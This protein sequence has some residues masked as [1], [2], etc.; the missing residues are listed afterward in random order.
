MSLKRVGFFGGT[1]DPIHFGHL[2]LAISIKEATKLDHI[3]FSPAHFSPEKKDQLPTASKKA[4]KEMTQL[5]IEGIEGFS[6]LEEE[7]D[8]EGPSYT[9]DTIQNLIAEHPQVQFH[10]I[11]GE[12]ILEGLLQWKEIEKLLELAPPLVGTRSGAQIPQLTPQVHQAIEKGKI[13]VSPMEISST[14]LRERLFQKKFSGHLVPS[15]V[16]DYIEMHKL[17]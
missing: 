13:E 16:L 17:Y 1:F 12:D 2:N 5:A 4:R 8:R 11:L 15:K 9:I 10:L 6:L 7:L 14:A 3:Y